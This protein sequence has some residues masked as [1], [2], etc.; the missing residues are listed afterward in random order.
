MGAC[1]CLLACLSLV[2]IPGGGEDWAAIASSKPNHVVI[3]PGAYGPDKFTMEFRHLLETYDNGA[4]GLSAQIWDWNRIGGVDKS[5][6]RLTES[7][8]MKHRAGRLVEEMK[9]WRQAP[10]NETAKIHLVG[11][12]AG[13]IVALL[14]AESDQLPTDFFDSIVFLSAYVSPGR[15]VEGMLKRTR[16]FYNYCSDEDKMLQALPHDALGGAGYHAK[17]KPPKTRQLRWQAGHRELGN[18]G[19]HLECCRSDFCRRFILPL[20]HSDKAV[21]PAEWK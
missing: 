9:K 12:S 21:I 2:L 15:N 17:N 18:H 16:A 13:S 7:E 8:V 5:A 20:F 4:G 19:A 1:G 3:L 14:A 11:L 10:A 6:D